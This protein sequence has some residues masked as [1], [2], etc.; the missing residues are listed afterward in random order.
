MI[1]KSFSERNSRSSMRY[2]RSFLL[3][4][5]PHDAT[6]VSSGPPTVNTKTFDNE[7][8]DADE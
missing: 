7:F 4:V 8:R 1:Q 6:V 2:N 3:T 5:G